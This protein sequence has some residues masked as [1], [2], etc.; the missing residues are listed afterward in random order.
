MD[1]FQRA[2]RYFHVG[3]GVGQ[4]GANM[5]DARLVGFLQDGQTL[6]IGHASS[7]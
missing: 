4:C 3:N 1:G 7:A 5:L 6:K 2:R